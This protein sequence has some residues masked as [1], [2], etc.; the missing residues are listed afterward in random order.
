MEPSLRGCNKQV[1]YLYRKERGD[2]YQKRGI[3]RLEEPACRPT[4]DGGDGHMDLL[5]RQ[6]SCDSLLKISLARTG[7]PTR[8]LQPGVNPKARS[9]RFE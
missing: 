1:K 9:K 4:Q 8:A 6:R 7:P 3:G 5:S 2:R